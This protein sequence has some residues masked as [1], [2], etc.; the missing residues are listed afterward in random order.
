MWID[1]LSVV[2]VDC[3]VKDLVKVSHWHWR[4]V[5]G[6]GGYGGIRG[7]TGGYGGVRG[8]TGG[9]GGVRGGTGGVRAGSGWGSEEAGEAGAGCG[10]WEKRGRRGGG[11]R[12]VTSEDPGY[13]SVPAIPST[14]NTS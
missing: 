11:G 7:D 4:G 9:Y 8:G 10:V 6:V 5:G 3:S 12:K 1:I 13:A 14:L 2:L